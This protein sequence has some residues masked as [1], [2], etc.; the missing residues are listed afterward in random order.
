MITVLLSIIL[1]STTL[2]AGVLYYMLKYNRNFLNKIQSIRG[3]VL[4]MI[5]VGEYAP[6]FRVIDENNNKI[7]ANHIFKEKSTLLIFAHSQCDACKELL[8]NLKKIES[9]YDINIIVNN[10]DILFDDSELKA[11]L[12]N[13]VYYLREEFL[14]NTYQVKSTPTVFLVKDHRVAAAKVVSKSSTLFNMLLDEKPK[15][16]TVMLKKIN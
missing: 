6:L 14:A 13:S 11:L 9:H 16:E 3:T 1:L 5:E 7:V 8:K 2:I 4:E 12:P 10:R 15:S